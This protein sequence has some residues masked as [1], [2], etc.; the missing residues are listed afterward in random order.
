M[1]N[2]PEN[3]LY[4][5]SHEWI[6]EAEDGTYILGITAYAADQMGGVVF[7]DLPDEDDEVEEGESFAEAESVKAVSEI[8]SPLTGTITEVNR[9]LED[10]PGL[11]ND[12]PYEAWI[13]KISDVT[14]KEELLD[15]AAYEAYVATL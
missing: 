5:K 1:S 10:E 14:D 12:K 13:V 9:D 6:E 2:Y 11:L 4:S 8:I 15:A 7:M 3:L